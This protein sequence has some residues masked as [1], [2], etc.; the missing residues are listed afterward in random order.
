MPAAWLQ[1][2]LYFQYMNTDCHFLHLKYTCAEDLTP[3][4]TVVHW[5]LVTWSISKTW[6]QASNGISFEKSERIITFLKSLL[7]NQY[8]LFCVQ[9]PVLHCYAHRILQYS[10]GLTLSSKS[11]ELLIIS[12]PGLVH[13]ISNQS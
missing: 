11:F 12:N 2:T 10:L 8:A 13:Q 4:S 1:S 5:V 9:L 6:N 3:D 7:C